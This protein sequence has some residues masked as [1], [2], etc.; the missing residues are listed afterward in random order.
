MSLPPILLV[1]DDENDVFF[2]QR[3]M[4]KAQIENPLHV[5]RD[6]RE[7]L[8]YL[9]G[10]APFTDRDQHPL[11]ALLVLDIN[12]P[13]YTGLEVL[14]WIREQPAF[15]TLIVLILTS[16]SSE[17]DVREAYTLGANSYLL[18]PGHPDEMVELLKV[19]N[20]YWLGL[21]RIVPGE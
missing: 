20:L 11:P 17:V 18:K 14:Q 13:H 7:G 19:V 15:R 4:R 3:A 9:A 8:N 12:L 6:G 2:F 16:S 5:A 21:N 10:K 1:E